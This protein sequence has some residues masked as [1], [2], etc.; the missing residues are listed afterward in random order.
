M[1]SPKDAVMWSRAD[2]SRTGHYEVP[3]LVLKVTAKMAEIEYL[4]RHRGQESPYKTYVMRT[5]L[6]R[7]TDADPKYAD[8]R[9]QNPD[10]SL[11]RLFSG[12]FLIHQMLRD[13]AQTKMEQDEAAYSKG[14]AEMDPEARYELGGRLKAAFE[15]SK[16]PLRVAKL[17][18]VGYSEAIRVYSETRSAWRKFR[19][20]E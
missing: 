8:G 18:G 4:R 14:L 5:S 9:V 3:A 10:G 7:A 19:G 1:I 6:R 12:C 15:A 16:A 2:W 11:R 17:S 13:L 20:W